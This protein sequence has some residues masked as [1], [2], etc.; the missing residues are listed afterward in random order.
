MPVTVASPIAS[1]AR[2]PGLDL[3]RGAVQSERPPGFGPR[4]KPSGTASNVPAGRGDYPEP[5]QRN[6]T[7]SRDVD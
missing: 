7:L 6:L 4:Q 2:D 5:P 3:A 1:R